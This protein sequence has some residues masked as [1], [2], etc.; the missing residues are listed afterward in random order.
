MSNI[1]C[2][3]ISEN[4]YKA[5]KPY[6]IVLTIRQV[7]LYH[8]YVVGACEGFAETKEKAKEMA[9]E[10]YRRYHEQNNITEHNK[11]RFFAKYQA[12]RDCLKELREIVSTGRNKARNIV[13]KKAIKK[14]TKVVKYLNER[15]NE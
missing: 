13:K 5:V 6:G 9:E 11:T 10:N 14:A 2:K 15:N 12:T 3:K 4:D 7:K 1:K 8:W